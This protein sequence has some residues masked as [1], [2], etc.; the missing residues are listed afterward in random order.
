VHSAP[1]D[2]RGADLE[3]GFARIGTPHESMQCPRALTRR[4]PA[5]SGWVNASLPSLWVYTDGS[6]LS[7]ESTQPARRRRGAR[8]APVYVCL[9]WTRQGLGRGAFFYSLRPI[10]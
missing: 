3:A 6:W 2:A 8:L 7:P 4:S 5:S 9:S 1:G 10:L